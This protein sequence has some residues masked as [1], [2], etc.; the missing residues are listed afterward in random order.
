VLVVD[1]EPTV[2]ML[3]A[4]VLTQL[5][6]TAVEAEDGPSALNILATDLRIDLLIS[7]VACRVV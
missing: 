6:Y 4:D 7:D 2:R 5:G 1:D 3:V